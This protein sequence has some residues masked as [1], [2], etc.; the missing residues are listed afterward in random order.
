MLKSNFKINEDKDASIKPFE[1]Y[2]RATMKTMDIIV[3]FTKL[4]ISEYLRSIS[5]F[6]NGK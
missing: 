4:Q 5:F 2:T 1:L 6:R 3:G